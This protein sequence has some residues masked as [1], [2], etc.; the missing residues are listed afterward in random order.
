ML[1]MGMRLSSGTVDIDGV[2]G[3]SGLAI[4]R[5]VAILVAMVF[6][7]ETQAQDITP[8]LVDTLTADSAFLVKRQE[9]KDFLSG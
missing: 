8:V 3:L 2:Q 5:M 6:A 1:F 4:S 9:S 7:Y